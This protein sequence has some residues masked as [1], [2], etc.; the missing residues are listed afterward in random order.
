MLNMFFFKKLSQETTYVVLY[1]SAALKNNTSFKIH[2]T[3]LEEK[4]KYKQL[5]C[6][7]EVLKYC[8]NTKTE[9]HFSLYGP[10]QFSSIL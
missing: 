4:Q 1:P 3:K 9:L 2:H 7:T 6:K 5:L 8:G 10:L